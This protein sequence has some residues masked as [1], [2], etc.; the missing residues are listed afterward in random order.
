MYSS[1]SS[2]A[3]SPRSQAD[4]LPSASP[5]NSFNRCDVVLHDRYRILKPLGHGD[6]KTFLALDEQTPDSFCVI[7]QLFLPHQASHQPR[8][9]AF[10]Q[11]SQRLADVGQHPQL[12]QLLD[13]FEQDGQAFIVQEWI[14][15]WTLEQ[16]VTGTVPFDEAEIW[17]LLRDL[18]PVLQCLHDHQIIHRDIKPANIIRRRSPHPATSL[19]ASGR[20]NLVLV[21]F[22]VATPSAISSRDANTLMGSA[23]YAAPEQ[24]RGQAVF[25]SDLY[26][27][28]LTCLYLLTQIAPF[29]LYDMGDAT[30]KWQA[31]L[32][33]PI[34]PALK[35]ILCTLLQPATRRRYQSAAAV[36][37]AVESFSRPT[38]TLHHLACPPASQVERTIAPII[39]HAVSTASYQSLAEMALLPTTI[40]AIKAARTSRAIAATVYSPQ[41][42]TWHCF[43]SVTE[44]TDAVDA[45]LWLDFHHAETTA[46]GYEGETRS[47]LIGEVS[48]KQPS[49][50]WRLFSLS[51]GTAAS[52]AMTC[53]W[54]CVSIIFLA[55]AVPPHLSAT[56][57]KANPTAAPQ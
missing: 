29:D 33:Q 41:T 19:Q 5:P 20:G 27:L 23:E 1:F 36:M 17:Q 44:A 13:A 4:T 11:A 34:S 55:I 26:G 51:L 16:E 32:P 38:Q 37:A 57:S 35:Q 31:Y 24:I 18:L 56:S 9:A 2:R 25:A 14:D 42:H 43:P 28:G 12:P 3:P 15:G 50:G 22:D 21:D 47:L 48:P 52:V 54:L 46:K 8:A 49:I 53:L 6:A 39:A 30:W 40:A 10:Q 45:V 7:K